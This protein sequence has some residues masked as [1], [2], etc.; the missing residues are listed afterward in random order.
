MTTIGYGDFNAAKHGDGY[1]KPDNMAL[2]CFL[3]VMAIFTFSLIQDRLFSLHFD[4]KIKDIVA[5]GIAE[6]E[7]FTQQLDQVKKRQYDHKKLNLEKGQKQP[8]RKHLDD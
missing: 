7:Y 3:E 6:T 8:E 2:V 5:K 4:I 1:N